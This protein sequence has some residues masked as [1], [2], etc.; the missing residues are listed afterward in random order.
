MFVAYFSDLFCLK[1]SAGLIG[2]LHIIISIAILLP[3]LLF[4][5]GWDFCVIHGTLIV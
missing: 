4:A 5:V 2:I 3:L 1:H